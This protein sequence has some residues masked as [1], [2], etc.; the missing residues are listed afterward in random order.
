MVGAGARIG[1][2]RASCF[3]L[4]ELAPDPRLVAPL[5]ARDTARLLDDRGPLY[6]PCRAEHQL[7]QWARSGDCQ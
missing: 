5:R 7:T 1:G 2:G 3:T 6:E 4:K